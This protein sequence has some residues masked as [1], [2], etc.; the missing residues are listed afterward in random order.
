VKHFSEK[1]DFSFGEYVAQQKDPNTSTMSEMER[2]K[3]EGAVGTMKEN[4]TIWDAVKTPPEE[5]LKK[6]MGGR[7]KG[8]TD[9]SPQ[10]RYW[11]ITEIFGPC[12]IGWKYKINDISIINGTDGQQVIRALIDFYYKYKGDWSDPIPGIGGSM[13]IAKEQAGLHVSDEAYKMA[14]TDALSVAL[15]M[16]GVGADVYM[17]QMG[18]KYNKPTSQANKE[19]AA[20]TDVPNCPVCQGPM[21]DNRG[22]GW[23]GPDC[24]C[25]DKSCQ[26]VIWKVAE[27]LEAEKQPAADMGEDIQLSFPGMEA[28]GD[29]NIDPDQKRKCFNKNS[30]FSYT[31]DTRENCKSKCSLYQ[32]A[33]GVLCPTW[34]Q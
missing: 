8:M 29:D 12:G 10:W 34:G 28:G 16:I 2:R 20:V 11:A 18:G 9:I 27:G 30:E 3:K 23:K 17:G 5:A 25:K 31:A 26:G 14:I 1:D 19:S 4:L 32:D 33:D 7:L 13:F 24:K 21:W 15:K 22:K 6:I